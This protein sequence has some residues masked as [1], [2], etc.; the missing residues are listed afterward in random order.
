MPLCL[1]SARRAALAA[2][3]ALCAA[4]GVNAQQNPFY[5]GAGLS[6]GHDSNVLRAPDNSA[7][8]QGDTYTT[9]YALIGID[10]PYGRQHYFANAT[11]RR[12]E[13]RDLDQLSNTGYDV[14]AGLDWEALDRLSGTLRF[15]LARARSQ[16]NLDATVVTERNL[17]T[18]KEFLARAQY[19]GQSILA[20][21]AEYAHRSIDYTAT[22][23]TTQENSSDSIRGGVLYN[24]SGALRLGAGVRY[25]DGKFPRAVQVAPGVFTEDKYTRRDLDLTARW[26]P[27]GAS[28]LNARLS[29]GKQENEALTNRDF[30]GTTGMVRWEWQPTG[31]LRFDTRLSRDTGFET[32]FLAFGTGAGGTAVGDTSRLTTALQIGAIWDVTSKIAID[33]DGRYTRRSLVNTGGITIDEKDRAHMFGVGATYKPTRNTELGCKLSREQRNTSGTLLTYP[34][35]ANVA[36]CSAQIVLR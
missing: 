14:N 16:Q 4:S 24:V 30:S 13:Y 22:A 28:I 31:K 6:V 1:P 12:T 18:A 7:L 26:V 15:G 20:L 23:F 8:N 25:T 33:F 29:Y 17:E 11:V 19:G 21:E 34:Y 27:S 35:S 2:A 5:V 32:S 3:A 9:G 10:K 36:L